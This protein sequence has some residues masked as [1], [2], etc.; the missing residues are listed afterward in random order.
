MKDDLKKVEIEIS[1]LKTEVSGIKANMATK[2]ELRSL[3]VFVLETKQHFDARFNW[4]H[5]GIDDVTLLVGN[6]EKDFKTKIKHHDKRLKRLEK[7]AGLAPLA[8]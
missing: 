2:Q 7:K 3:H 6:K 1:D 4:L 5:E 8:A